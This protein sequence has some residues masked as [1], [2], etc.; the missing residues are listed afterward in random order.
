MWAWL[1]Q[2]QPIGGG[3]T[4]CSGCVTEIGIQMAQTDD[5]D[6]MRN[7]HGQLKDSYRADTIW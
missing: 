2:V 7:S 6:Q 3:A 1:V 5:W 4:Y